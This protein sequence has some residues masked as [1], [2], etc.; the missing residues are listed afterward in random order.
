[1]NKKLRMSNSVMLKSPNCTSVLTWAK[2]KISGVGGGKFVISYKITFLFLFNLHY[3][4]YYAKC[5][6][7]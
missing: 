2:K 5:L 1:M 7:K 3:V 6:G 4:D